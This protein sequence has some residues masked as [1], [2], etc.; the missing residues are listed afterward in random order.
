M[1]QKHFADADELLYY[2]KEYLEECR[3]Q[4]LTP[5][6]AGFAA[7]CFMSKQT[8]LNYNETGHPFF[9]AMQ[10]ILVFLEDNYINSKNI[11]DKFKEFMLKNS[12]PETYREKQELDIRQENI[13][14]EITKSNE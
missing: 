12:Y 6:K 13:I 11:S 14:V 7:K 10:I 4:N 5:N 3:E 8:L 9:D 2:F 1:R